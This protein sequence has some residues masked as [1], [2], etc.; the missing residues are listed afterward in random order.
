[1]KDSEAASPL[2]WSSAP[3]YFYSKHVVKKELLVS[4]CMRMFKTLECVCSQRTRP[5]HSPS[6]LG[7][8]EQR[9]LDKNAVSL[10]KKFW[11]P[12]TP[13]PMGKPDYR[14]N[15]PA[16][17]ITHQLGQTNLHSLLNLDLK[18]S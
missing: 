11:E 9:D 10:E 15:Y 3:T 17:S 1:M 5:S 14:V 8:H 16:F 7:V 13:V 6:L 4:K 18:V 12:D 2:T